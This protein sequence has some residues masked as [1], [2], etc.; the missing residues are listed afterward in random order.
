[1]ATVEVHRS[2]SRFV[3]RTEWVTAYHSF[4]FGDHYDPD[5]TSFAALQAHNEDHVAPDGGYDMHRHRDTEIVTWVLSGSLVHRDSHTP[6]AVLRPGMVQRVGAGTGITHSERNDAWR[7]LDP[8]ALRV[9]VQFVQMWV[10]PDRPGHRPH[11]EH[12]D[13][14][15]RL[16]DGALVTLASGRRSHRDET[17]T[18]INNPSAALHVARLGS[19]GAQEEAASVLLPDAPYLHLFVG[20]GEVVLEGVGRLRQGD[21]ARLS[22]SGGRR[23]SA[24]APAE[25]LL[26]EMHSVLGA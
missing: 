3:T 22:A 4:S 13:V 11:Y 24:S 14:T 8:G 5:N 18:K 26:W 20:R 23:V 19:A 25:I 9:P 7:E 2:E 16:T 6:A 1:M 10:A 17:A 12:H 15:D 21:A